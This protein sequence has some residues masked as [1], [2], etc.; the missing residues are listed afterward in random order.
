MPST[1]MMLRWV[2]FLLGSVA[3][4]APAAA[5]GAAQDRFWPAGGAV[6]FVA[7][8]DAFADGNDR[9]YTSGVLASMLVEHDAAPRWLQWLG[10]EPAR[11]FNLE[12]QSVGFAVGHTLYT[13]EDIAADI[14]PPDQHP[15][16]GWA[17]ATL[18]LFAVKGP[19]RL[20]Q[21]DLTIGVVGPLAGG[22]WV[23]TEW[24][25]MLRAVEPRGWSSQLEN[26][27][28][29]AIDYERRHRGRLCP[30][31][32]VVGCDLVPSF[33]GALG[34]LRA[35][36]RVG[37]TFRAGGGL[38]NDFGPPRIRPALAGGGLTVEQ[39]G[40]RVYSFV[41]VYGRA[42]GR[43]LFLDGNSFEEGP[44]VERKPLVGELQAGL[45][46]QF[47]GLQLSYTFVRR[48]EEFQTQ[49]EPQQFGAF[50]LAHR[51]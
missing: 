34:T 11:L 28:A 20:D 6:S 10:R 18:S 1:T 43:N 14:A 16:A 23:Q 40:A 30:E 3:A 8:N 46:L 17:Y 5:Q 37:V 41:G 19:D 42:V 49:T 24:H 9:N 25:D 4:A 36:A 26:E 33:G 35:E 45:V 27:A 21:A 39:P 13:P 2:G 38:E 15:Y 22:E 31:R 29:F 47:R 48:T 7:E 12:P 44:R 32:W 50:A 51:W